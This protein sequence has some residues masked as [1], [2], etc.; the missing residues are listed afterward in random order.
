M[1]KLP[2][3][4][5]FASRVLALLIIL[6]VPATL[7]VTDSRAYA[8]AKDPKAVSQE[9][10]PVV[11]ATKTLVNELDDIDRLR[12]L[13]PLK[14]SSE[15][16][17]KLIDFLTKAQA[18]YERKISAIALD[19]LKEI[20]DEIKKTKKETLAGG[21]ITKEFDA[22]VKKI[23]ADFTKKKEALWIENI[24]KSSVE[25]K[26][27]LSEEQFAAAAKME[28]AEFLKSRPEVKGTDEQMFNQY[29]VDTFMSYYRIVPLLKEMKQSK[30]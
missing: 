13:N 12:I 20:A 15:Q 18:D 21:S 17:T 29:V 8:Q 7:C 3:R 10:P 27:I 25:C 30:S 16:L 9:T 2:Y 11:E 28:K 26:R 23:Q 6:A 24:A 1:I 14:L 19:P 5:S 4:T 22:K